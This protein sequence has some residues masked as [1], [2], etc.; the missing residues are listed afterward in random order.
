MHVVYYSRYN[1]PSLGSMGYRF[2]KTYD[3]LTTLRD[4]ITLVEP[5]PA[6]ITQTHTPEYLSGTE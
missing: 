4:D 3:A 5:E 1:M 6:D 2:Q